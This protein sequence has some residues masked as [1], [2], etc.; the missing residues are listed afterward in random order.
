MLIIGVDIMRK[1]LAIALAV[2]CVFSLCA[3]GSKDTGEKEREC[4]VYITME[5]N[6][7]FTVSCGTDE[8]SGEFLLGII[9]PRNFYVRLRKG[10]DIRNLTCYYIYIL[11]NGGPHEI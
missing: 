5:A 11:Q 10:I 2:C 1:F 7:V 3:C 9:S 6:D 8:G 4:G